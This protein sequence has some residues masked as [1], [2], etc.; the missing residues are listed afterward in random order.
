MKRTMGTRTTIRRPQKIRPDTKM[1][2]TSEDL[3]PTEDL[4]ITMALRMVTTWAAVATTT[5]WLTMRKG[6]Q[7][8]ATVGLATNSMFLFLFAFRK[9]KINDL[10][11]W[12]SNQ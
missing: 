1:A 12:R 9:I 2:G 3:I 4:S 10:P 7:G 6:F 8:P 11:S 5:E